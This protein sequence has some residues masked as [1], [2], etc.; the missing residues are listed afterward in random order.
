MGR[1]LRPTIGAYVMAVAVLV[2][3]LAVFVI[4]PPNASLWFGLVVVGAALIGGALSIGASTWNRHAL[5]TDRVELTDDEIAAFFISTDLPKALVLELWHEAA[6]TLGMKSGKLR[7]S[8]RLGKDVGTYAITSDALDE[9]EAIARKRAS[10]SNVS[11]ELT[12]VLTLDQYI[13]TVGEAM[14]ASAKKA[15]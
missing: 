6:T 4:N 7:P 15:P 9:L 3:V 1:L 2:G 11:L 14:A 5:V 10:A 13:R 12:H 8:D